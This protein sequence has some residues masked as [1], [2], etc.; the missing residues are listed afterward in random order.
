MYYFWLCWVSVAA[1]R[2]SL[3]AASRELLSCCRVQALGCMGSVV[4]AQV[5]SRSVACDI[6]L[7]QGLNPCPLHWQAGSLP[8][9]DQGSPI[10][11]FLRPGTYTLY[12]M[13]D[14]G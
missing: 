14:G 12:I 9:S 8:L 3:D 5:L 6:F 10:A 1:Y 13:I 4:V 2:L 11:L 7:D